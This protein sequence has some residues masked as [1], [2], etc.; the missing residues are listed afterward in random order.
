MELDQIVNLNDYPIGDPDFRDAARE[1]F[2]KH[3]ILV[4]P[5]FATQTAI[6]AIHAQGCANRD[7][8]F[9]STEKHTVYL[10]P[11]DPAF[12]IQHPRNR[13]VVSSKG[14]IT[15]DLVP[16]DSAL[17]T[18]YDAPLFR[19]FLCSVLGETALYEYADTLSSINLHFAETG[20]ELGW[21]FDNSSFSITLMVQPPESGGQFEYVGGIRDA[22]TGDMAY[23]AVGAILDGHTKVE[24]LVADAGTLV[25]FR[26]RNSI[27]RVAPNKGKRTR[28]LAVL[29]YNNEQGISLSEEARKTFYGRTG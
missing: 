14:C 1:K 8:V 2:E 13:L 3:G 27:H 23:E 15:D 12:D 22:D 16:E 7:R 17:R 6:A 9:A 18:L 10:S 28:M 11:T 19:D 4:M 20:Q 21:H 25:F 5:G 29:A 26:G 24:Q